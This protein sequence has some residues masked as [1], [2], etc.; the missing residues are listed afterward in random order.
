MLND[1]FGIEIISNESNK[2]FGR[3]VVKNTFPL[4]FIKY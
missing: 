3:L 2:N 1:A 4:D